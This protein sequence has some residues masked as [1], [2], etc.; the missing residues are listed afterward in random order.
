[1]AQGADMLGEKYAKECGYE[2]HYYPADWK[3]YGRR[4][5]PIRNEKMAQA[6]DALVAFWDGSSP[7]TK[8]MIE[9]AKQYNLLIRIKHY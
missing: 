4:A 2:I 3:Q 7:G 6:A 9:I 8:N 1:M 5:G